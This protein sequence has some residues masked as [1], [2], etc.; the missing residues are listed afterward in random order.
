M[1]IVVEPEENLS[2][3]EIASRLRKAANTLS[4]ILPE[5]KGSRR[6]PT[7]AGKQI[8]EHFDK[9]MKDT[10]DKTKKDIERILA[11]A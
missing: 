8:F 3:S 6:F 4:P 9:L 11:N 5:R 10:I 7:V 1:K 2:N